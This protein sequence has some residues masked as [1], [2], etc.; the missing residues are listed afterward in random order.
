VTEVVSVQTAS[1]AATVDN[2]LN[3]QTLTL[4]G[5]RYTFGGTTKTHDMLT[6]NIC[7]TAR[8]QDWYKCDDLTGENLTLCRST[9]TN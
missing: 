5:I 8:T 4:N 7:H 9:I 1:G 2:C 3:P 6:A